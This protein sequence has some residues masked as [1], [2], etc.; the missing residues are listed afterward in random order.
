MIKT[1]FKRF[2]QN[3]DSCSGSI[4]EHT[5]DCQWY[6]PKVRL[7]HEDYVGSHID[8]HYFEGEDEEYADL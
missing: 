7:S 2:S 6:E 5:Q 3:C 4:N 8:P 1:T